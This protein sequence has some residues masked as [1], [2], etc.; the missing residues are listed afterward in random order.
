MSRDR[1]GDDLTASSSILPD[2]AFLELFLVRSA[3][4]VAESG[5]QDTPSSPVPPSLLVRKVFCTLPSKDSPILVK[6]PSAIPDWSEILPDRIPGSVL[7]LAISS[8][9]E[10]L[11]TRSAIPRPHL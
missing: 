7:I 6:R 4:V 3:S 11:N 8:A 1:S 2:T 5:C 9:L 10:P